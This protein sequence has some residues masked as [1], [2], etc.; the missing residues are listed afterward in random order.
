MKIN[1][2]GRTIVRG[3]LIVAAVLCALGWWLL[4]MWWAW[5]VTVVAMFAAAF[6]GHF[7][8]MPHRAPGLDA[9]LVYSPA[10][11]EVVVCE[12]VFEKEYLGRE[13]IQISIFMSLSS[14]H[15]N[16]YPVGGE[17]VY[18]RRHEGDYMVAWHPKSSEDN[19]HTTTVVRTA[20][21][22]EVL[23]RQVAGYVARRI[24]S[25]ARQGAQVEQSTKCGFI[26]FGSRVDVLLPV[27]SVPLVRIGDKV[28]GAQ[29][30]IAKL[31][32]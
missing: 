1:P 23:F 28:H 7:F 18:F 26:K 22:V 13:C 10:D 9:S 20:G 27:E 12:Q 30:P 11:G 6:T 19:E 4:P 31:K 14:V 3:T 8:R 16:W 32:V 17:V 2:E 21:G 29:T 25:Y 15:M 5:A 24:V